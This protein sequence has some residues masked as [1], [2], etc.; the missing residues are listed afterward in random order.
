MGNFNYKTLRIQNINIME[1]CKK[2]IRKYFF[3]NRL[4]TGSDD[5]EF[6]EMDVES[7]HAQRRELTAEEEKLL[8]GSDDERRME[9]NEDTEM[10]E[11]EDEDEARRRAEKEADEEDQR[12]RHAELTERIRRRKEERE[13]RKNEQR[14]KER[15]LLAAEQNRLREE[16]EAE[17]R[18][19]MERVRKLEAELKKAR[20]E[21]GSSREDKSGGKRGRSESVESKQESVVS[22]TMGANML[23]LPAGYRAVRS[24]KLNSLAVRHLNG[25]SAIPFQPIGSFANDQDARIRLANTISDA[26]SS[27]NIS[28]S[29]NLLMG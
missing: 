15:E 18:A 1:A 21:S 23:N 16:A 20:G 22:N 11:A 9:K 27:R 17:T 12:A 5:D 28:S 29:F 13:K 26:N 6:G 10:R 7:Q 25:G 8:Y 3:N 2:F 19:Q 4:C 24:T 14:L